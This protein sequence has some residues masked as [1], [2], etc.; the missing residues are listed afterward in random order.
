MKK[1]LQGIKEGKKDRNIVHYLKHK[2]LY[3]LAGMCK[4]EPLLDALFHDNVQNP[5]NKS[6]GSSIQN[7]GN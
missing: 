7:L 2:V 1:D 3:T 6:Y 4:D 5:N